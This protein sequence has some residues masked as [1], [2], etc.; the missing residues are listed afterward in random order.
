MSGLEILKR[1]I[2]RSTQKYERTDGGVTKYPRYFLNL[3]KEFVEKHNLEETGLWLV[4][5]QVWFGLPNEGTLMK[6]VALLP[7]IK[8]LISKE[9]GLSDE[10]IEKLLELNPEIRKYL[11]KE[12]KPN[13]ESDDS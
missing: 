10:D 12:K 2:S 3:P 6:V 9:G 11:A 4:A 1:A 7:E 13:N 8:E 5:D